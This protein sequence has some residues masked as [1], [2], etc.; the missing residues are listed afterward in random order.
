MEDVAVLY[1]HGYAGRQQQGD[2]FGE[3]HGQKDG[4]SQY[5]FPQQ[6]SPVKQKKEEQEVTGGK[7]DP[8]CR[9]GRQR[10][11]GE[12]TAPRTRRHDQRVIVPRG[13]FCGDDR[14]EGIEKHGL[15]DD[16]HEQIG[17]YVQGCGRHGGLSF[18]TIYVVCGGGC[19]WLPVYHT[20]ICRKTQVFDTIY[21]LNDIKC[22]VAACGHLAKLTIFHYNW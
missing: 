19:F 7:E 2:H 13:E 6:L 20:K 5:K 16:I 11:I 10:V 17:E 1:M 18:L 21:I 14:L 15:L 9:I 8:D 4:Q 22:I 3:C 12:K